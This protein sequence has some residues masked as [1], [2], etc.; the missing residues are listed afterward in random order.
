MPRWVALLLAAVAI[1]LS[2]VPVVIVWA[3][4]ALIGHRR[5]GQAAVA[6]DAL[7]SC[8]TGGDWQETI[9]M[10]ANRAMGN[11]KRW[12]CVLCKFLD[13]IDPDH[14]RKYG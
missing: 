4:L 6:W 12:G 14:C 11:G 8:L 1:I 13:R 9:T 10:R 2:I 3:C 5:A 7:V